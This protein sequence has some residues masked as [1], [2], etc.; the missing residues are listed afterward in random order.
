[1]KRLMSRGNFLRVAAMMFLVMAIA[2]PVYPQISIVPENAIPPNKRNQKP[3]YEYLLNFEKNLKECGF[4][5]Q[6][7]LWDLVP[8]VGYGSQAT[9]FKKRDYAQVVRQL[10]GIWVNY[11]DKLV[12]FRT[13]GDYL[14]E[15]Q[16]VKF[17]Q[18][19]D[20]RY[21]ID[22][23]EETTAH[24]STDKNSHGLTGVSSRSAAVTQEVVKGAEVT[25]VTKSANGIENYRIYVSNYIASMNLY[26]SR[27]DKTVPLI[28]HIVDEIE[29]IMNEC[30]KE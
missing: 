10:V 13:N 23:Y 19:T 24:V 6:I 29:F 9:Y 4:T 30:K 1:M 3:Y 14:V 11:Q 22:S 27:F 15:G 17:S 26:D 25:V 20:V 8:P 21:K 28:Q 2:A 7:T 18:I 5:K 16:V 12:M